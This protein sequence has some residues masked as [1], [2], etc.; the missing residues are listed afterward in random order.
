MRT[1][2][3]HK[4]GNNKFLQNAMHLYDWYNYFCKKSQITNPQSAHENWS[5]PDWLTLDRMKDLLSPSEE[6]R[7]LS[8]GGFSSHAFA[9]HV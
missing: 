6:E 9:R 2:V 3:Y 5:G 4:S 8:T 7:M 1:S